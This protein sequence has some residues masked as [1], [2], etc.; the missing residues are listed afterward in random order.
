MKMNQNNFFNQLFLRFT[1]KSPKFFVWIQLVSVI[2]ASIVALPEFLTQFDI[3]IIVVDNPTW[4]AVIGIASAVAFII[5][6]LPVSDSS[7][8]VD[9]INSK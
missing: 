6:K 4:K 5:S 3:N 9:Q 2:C 7:N 8:K 1:S